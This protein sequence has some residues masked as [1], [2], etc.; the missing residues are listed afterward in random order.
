M[1]RQPLVTI[2]IPVFNEEK[3][4]SSMIENTLAQDYDNLEVLI[5]DIWLLKT[6]KVKL[7]VYALN[8]DSKHSQWIIRID[9][10]ERQAS[11]FQLNTVGT[12]VMYE[13]KVIA[14]SE[15]SHIAVRVECIDIA[16]LN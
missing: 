12:H 13:L 10:V 7:H 11:L 3:Y 15:E 2:C 14:C 4:L 5:S 6:K 16:D 8:E 9:G 1:A